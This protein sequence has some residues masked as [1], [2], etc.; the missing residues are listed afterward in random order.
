MYEVEGKTA[1]VT[2][3][4][5]GIGLG[6]ARSFAGAGMSVVLADI[7]SGKIDCIICYKLD[8]LT[9]SLLDFARTLEI[10]ERNNVAL[11]SVTQAFDTS[12]ASGK[13]RMHILMSSI[14]IDGW[15]FSRTVFLF[16]RPLGAIARG[17]SCDAHHSAVLVDSMRV[18][19]R[20]K[21][22]YSGAAYHESP[23]SR[24]VECNE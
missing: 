23:A 3:A 7:E 21:P 4:A 18:R 24:A 2:G 22:T 14:D 10:L 12:T 16:A 1:V 5:S 11:V 20:R 15:P 6:M 13:P 9:R 19:A 17:S 8:R